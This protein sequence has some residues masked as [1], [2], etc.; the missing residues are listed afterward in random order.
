MERGAGGGRLRTFRLGNL[1]DIA[2]LAIAYFAAGYVGITLAVPPGYASIVWPASGV[3][4]CALLWGGTRLLPGVWLGSFGLNVMAGLDTSLDFERGWTVFAIAAALGIG[5]TLQA[6]GGFLLARRFADGIEI[7]HMRRL[8]IAAFLVVIIPCAIAP[9]IGSATLLTTGAIGFDMLPSN[10]LTWYAGDVLGVL[11]IIPIL[12]LSTWSPVAV[13]WHGNS[14]Q[15]ANSLVA[16]SLTT[17]LF[18]TF[19]A[20]QFI[21]EREYEQA[22]TSFAAMADDTDEALRHRLQIYER[23]LQSAAAFAAFEGEISPSRW[24]EYVDRLDIARSYPGMRGFGMFQAVADDDLPTFREQFDREFGDRFEVHPMVDRDEHFVIN[25]IEPL[26]N[27]L[28]ALGL[29]LAFER[30][31]REAI[32][33]SKTRGGAVLTRPIVLVQDQKKGAGFLLVFSVRNEAG[34]PS[35]RWTYSPLIADELLASLNPRQG[36]EFALE[37]YHGAQT[38]PDALLYSTSE[39]ASNPK[40]EIRRTIDLAGQPFTL[41]WT[42]L[43]PFERRHAS[44]AP[45]I[46]LT[47]GF[48]ITILLGI[49]LVTF[50]RRES[51]VLRE[52]RD[53]TAELA[54]RNRMLE[55]A[56]ATAHIGHW[57]LDLRDSRLRWSDEVHRMHGLKPG[58]T[59]TLDEGI[60]FYH[61][62]DRTTVRQSLDTALSD[63]R[64][65]RFKARIHT[66]SGE[67]RHVEVRGNVDTDENGKAVCIF[68][69]IIDRTDETL[70]RERLTATIEEARAADQ[71]KSSFLANMSHEIRTPMNGLIGFT[72]LALAEEKKPEQRRRLRM[73]ADSSNA[74]LRLLNDL[75][76]FAKIEAKQ[77]AIVNEPTDLRHTLRSC[78]RLMEPVAKGQNLLLLLEIDPALPPRV[79]VDKMRLRQIVLNLV[80]NALKFTEEG[81]VK[82]LASLSRTAGHADRIVITVRDT[83]IGIPA[84]RLDSLFNKFIQADDTTARR[85][86]GT[87]L[88][89][90]IS[91]ELAEL[92]GG[93]LS[94]ESEPGKGSAFTLSLPL[95]VSTGVANSPDLPEPG[96]ACEQTVR[97]RILVAEDNPVNQELTAAMV[98]KVGHACDLARDGQEAIDAVMQA[99]REGRP[100]DMVLMDMQMPRVDGLAATR[101]I[102]EMGIGPETLPILALTANAYSDDIQR[103]ENAGMQ[104]HL[105][106]PLRLNELS[107]AIAE[108]SR[109]KDV[110]ADES[111]YSFEEETDPRLRA[112]FDDRK[113]ELAAVIEAAISRQDVS[114]DEKRT[115]AGLLHEIAGVAAFFGQADLGKECRD[116]EVELLQLTNPSGIRQLL[117][118]LQMRLAPATPRHEEAPHG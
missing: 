47:S 46:V 114:E 17:T 90:S 92:M 16:M 91:A 83:G 95:E 42:S 76:D 75:L 84:D 7:S 48:M 33:L 70:M 103:C 101:A 115:I 14:L 60:D 89:L 68:G 116:W 108:W 2:L 53:A 5:A 117:Q 86:G 66:R 110:A 4:L 59:P 30:G 77:M 73:I 104:A 54:E 58:H 80:G 105:A 52:V 50:L 25:R 13:R 22:K 69:V 61:P 94:A 31:R 32:A 57:D 35:G 37:V 24:R 100:Y 36:E 12:L 23:A 106:K 79:Q 85:Y 78:Q 63:C 71:A 6:L 39:T 40:F 64:P 9:T 99:E 28:A 74:M 27:N 41:R 102:R 3:A 107:A 1:R 29:D 111:N 45:L 96:A 11:L 38:V 67:L 51:H 65:Y 44:S 18:L 97:L 112:M 113:A 72:E 98:E 87:G 118:N 8:V 26:A 20:W 49:L 82:V 56:E 10:W 88:G 34:E 109:G 21:S 15:G 43:Q 55:M 93:E 81:E 62:E 19:Y